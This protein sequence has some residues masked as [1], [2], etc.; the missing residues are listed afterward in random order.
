[1]SEKDEV[2][3][4]MGRDNYAGL[5]GLKVVTARPGYAEVSLP[6]TEKI[7][8]GHGNVH[9]G[10]IFTLADYAAA[11]ASNM[12][13]E[14]TMATGGSISYLRAVRDGYLLAKATTVKAGRRM[15]FQVVDIYDAEEELVAT[16][17]GGA[18]NVFRN[19][20]GP[21]S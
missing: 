10:A 3:E 4:I 15:K 14:P 19:N 2:F 18:I 6:V 13:G 8:N 20:G 16:F 21:A 1:M 7:M 17:Q 9:G 11:L 12:F 5:T